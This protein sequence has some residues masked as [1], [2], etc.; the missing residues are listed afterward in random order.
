MDLHP[1]KAP[2]SILDKENETSHDIYC[3]DE[4]PLNENSLIVVTQEG[5]YICFNDLQLQNEY[6]PIIISEEGNTI[7]VKDVHS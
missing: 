4:Q 7:F 3:M 5:I 1:K 2:S 6:S